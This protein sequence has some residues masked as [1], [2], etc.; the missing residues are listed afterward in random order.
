MCVCERERERERESARVCVGGVEWEGVCECVWLKQQSI[1]IPN[2]SNKTIQTSANAGVPVLNRKLA[3]EK[4][5]KTDGTPPPHTHTHTEKQKL[6][7]VEADGIWQK[8]ANSWRREGRQGRREGGREEEQQ[9]GEEEEEKDESREVR[10]EEEEETGRDGRRK[11]AI[12]W[13][14]VAAR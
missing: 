7:Q 14:F 9:E 13:P 6:P 8:V 12:C 10:G 3:E 2:N 1:T 4:R 11:P 5:T